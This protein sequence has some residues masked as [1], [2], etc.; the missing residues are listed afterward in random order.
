[1]VR[2][3]RRA[4][5]EIVGSGRAGT[6]RVVAELVSLGALGLS[7]CLT[8]AAASVVSDVAVTRANTTGLAASIFALVEEGD[9]AQVVPGS[10]S[11]LPAPAPEG[12]EGGVEDE[13]VQGELPREAAPPGEAQPDEGT[14]PDA[15]AEEPGAD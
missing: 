11:P 9:G 5:P 4:R 8:T 13:A 2:V 14:V 1:M 3:P 15:A 6:G 12:K 7:W 10:G